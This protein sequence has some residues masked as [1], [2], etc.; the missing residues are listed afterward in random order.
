[1]ASGPC[2]QKARGGIDIVVSNAAS[3]PYFGPLTGIT[4]EAFDKI[5]TSNLKSVLWLAGMT[6]DPAAVWRTRPARS[7]NLWLT[8]WAS[9]GL[10]LRTGRKQRETRKEGLS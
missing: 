3:N 6:L 5:L 4:D 7:I 2:I 10:S 9:A 8:I 1:M